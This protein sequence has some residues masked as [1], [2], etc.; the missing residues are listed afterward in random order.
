MPVYARLVGGLGNQ[1]FQY[2]NGF[3]QS[4]R[5]GVPFILD[6]RE[7]S[8]ARTAHNVFALDQFK[9]S[10][11]IGNSA[12]L[13]PPRTSRLRYLAWRKFGRNPKHFR[14]QGFAFNPKIMDASGHRSC[15]K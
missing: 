3:A 7:L 9:I 8:G 2:A 12:V 5:L 11:T 10:A 13:P 15:N 1:L 6:T 4:Q 14:E